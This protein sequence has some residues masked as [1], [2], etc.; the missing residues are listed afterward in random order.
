[1]FGILINTIHILILNWKSKKQLIL[2]C[3]N[4]DKT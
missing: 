3:S 4:E 2:F 1:M